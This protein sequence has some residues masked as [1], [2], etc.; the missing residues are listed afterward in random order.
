MTTAGSPYARALSRSRAAFLTM[1]GISG[2]VNILT[3]TGSL[4]MLQV[5]DRVLPSRQVPTL[6]AL[7]G[8]VVFLYAV[9]AV[10]EAIRSRMIARIGRRLDEDL[11]GEAFRAAVTLP[12]LANVGQDRIDPVRDLDQ[13]RQFASSPGPAALF[14]LPWVPLY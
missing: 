5:Y 12:L 7:L 4:F 13:V 3:L 2:A 8:V 9:Q 14:D 1:G 11:Q 6:V 10:L